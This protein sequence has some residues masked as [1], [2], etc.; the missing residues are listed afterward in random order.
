MNSMINKSIPLVS[1]IIPTYNREKTLL[2]AIKSV[3]NQEYDR[4]EIIIV[5]D[6][7]TDNTRNI[8]ESYLKNEN[9]FYIFQKN[10]GVCAARNLGIEKANGEYIALLDSDDEFSPDKL[11]IQINIM[12]ASNS[13]FSVSNCAIINENQSTKNKYNNNFLVSEEQVINNEIP[14][15][16]SLMLF[17]KDLCREFLFDEELPTANDLDFI[18]RVL[19]KNRILFIK[20]EL[21]KIHKTLSGN[22][23]SCDYEKK[24]VGYKKVLEK[25]E[26]GQ[27]I[28]NQE[29][30]KHISKKI[31][32][33][34]GQFCSLNS[35]F[36]DGRSYFM[37][38]FKISNFSSKLFK[39]Y[40]MY[41]LTYFPPL[42]KCTV[43]L[44]KSLWKYGLVKT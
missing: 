40:L 42:F 7:S 12:K 26:S 29:Q 6:G 11:S 25:A 23:I 15:S 8:I 39:Y 41:T 4:Y 16:A 20:D 10:K 35:N 28:F 3:L 17:R 30:I 9:I 22:R 43:Q 38:G 13:I 21:T 14:L 27:Y 36:V 37:K 24:I 32:L 5:D 2:R 34:L 19:T 18:L 44:G 31:Y 1:I 33:Q